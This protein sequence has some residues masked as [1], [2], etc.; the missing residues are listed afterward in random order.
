MTKEW[1]GNMVKRAM[2][3]RKCYIKTYG[4]DMYGVSPTEG[5]QNG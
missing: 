5:K 4:V 3:A 2:N 1:E